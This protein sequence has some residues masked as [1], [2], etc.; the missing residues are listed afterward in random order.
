VVWALLGEYWR[1]AVVGGSGLLVLVLRRRVPRWVPAAWALLAVAVVLAW[2]VDMSWL[3]TLVV[4]GGLVLIA[5][6]FWLRAEERRATSQ[7]EPQ[8]PRFMES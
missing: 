7:K 4:F 8:P 6:A 3:G 5:S 1:I 2:L